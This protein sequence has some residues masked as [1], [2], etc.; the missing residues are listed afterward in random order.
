VIVAA[1]VLGLSL[2]GSRSRGKCDER[3][4]Q[5]SALHPSSSMTSACGGSDR[6]R[7]W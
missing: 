7:A 2:C 1:M 4:E 3:D 6:R 5:Q